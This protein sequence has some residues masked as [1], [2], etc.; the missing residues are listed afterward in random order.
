MVSN[1]LFSWGFVACLLGPVVT[2][3]NDCQTRTVVNEEKTCVAICRAKLGREPLRVDVLGR[4]GLD[5]WRV[6]GC[7]LDRKVVVDDLPAPA[8]AEPKK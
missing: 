6:C 3:S 8:E 4:T 7:Y 5:Q 1:R 2:E